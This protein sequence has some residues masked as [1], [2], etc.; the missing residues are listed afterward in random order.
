MRLVVGKKQTFSR[1]KHSSGSTGTMDA[2]GLSDD[3]LFSSCLLNFTWENSFEQQTG[4][5]MTK[6][7]ETNFLLTLHMLGHVRFSVI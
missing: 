5:G 7:P 1:K 3:E 4:I 2:Y 6:K